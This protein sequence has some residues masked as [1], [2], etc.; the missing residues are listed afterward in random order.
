M[1]EVKGGSLE[2]VRRCVRMCLRTTARGRLR[3][4]RC[5]SREGSRG[6]VFSTTPDLPHAGHGSAPGIRGG[7]RGPQDSE[8]GPGGR[9]LIPDHGNPSLAPCAAVEIPEWGGRR[10]PLPSPWPESRLPTTR[11][12]L[13]AFG[14]Q[15][16][17]PGSLV[18]PEFPSSAG[19]PQSR[20]WPRPL[21]QSWGG[22]GLWLEPESDWREG[23]RLRG[24]S[25]RTGPLLE[26]LF[27]DTLRSL[28]FP[29]QDH[30]SL[31]SLPPS[32]L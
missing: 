8:T 24:F 4:L 17:S 3:T 10:K 30:T 20:G 25:L 26:A 29:S 32:P 6:C 23:G 22:V 11:R 16:R 15:R 19:V 2:P 27:V 28:R 21:W 9:R 14:S 12:G 18:T 31:P 13:P 5:L 7:K 1:F